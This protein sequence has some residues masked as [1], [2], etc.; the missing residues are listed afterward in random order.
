MTVF[1]GG[2]NGLS[3]R[4]PPVLRFAP[5][6]N[7]RLH[8]G[9]ASSALLNDQIARAGRG[10]WL[11]RLEDIDPVRATPEN[12]AGILEDL[13]WLG[14]CW[15]DPVR[16]QSEHMAFYAAMAERLREQGILYRCFCTRSDI[17]V[18]VAER[19]QASGTT[20]PRDPDGSSLYPGTCRELPAAV[21]ATRAANGEAHAWRLDMSK[22]VADREPLAWTRF[23]RDWAETEIA[24][25]PE[26]WGDPVI[27]RKDVPTSYHLAVVVDDDAQGVTHVVR[28]SDLLAATDLHALLIR[29]L[30]LRA[31]CYHHHGLLVG[32]DGAK[33]SKSRGSQSLASLR[34]AGVSAEDIRDRL[35]FA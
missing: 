33:L 28:G 3:A 31:P 27:I 11:L 24:A 1:A 25:H 32:P 14:L 13:S 15:P 16:R 4:R 6:P 2:R 9:H 5:S 34:G 18:A 23:D 35:G 29:R 19:E 10:V 12:V 21:A 17:A 20:W 30:R 8:L 7:G 22:A 26:R